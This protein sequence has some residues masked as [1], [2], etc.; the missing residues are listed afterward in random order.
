MSSPRNQST[1]PFGSHEDQAIFLSSSYGDERDSS[2]HDE[3]PD[4]TRGN[5]ELPKK[6]KGKNKEKAS[7]LKVTQE[8]RKNDQQPTAHTNIEFGPPTPTTPKR[9]TSDNSYF[10]WAKNA[11]SNTVS[12]VENGLNALDQKA[13]RVANKSYGTITSDKSSSSNNPKPALS[14]PLAPRIEIDIPPSMP[15]STFRRIIDDLIINPL[16]SAAHYAK[17]HPASVIIGFLSSIPGGIYSFCAFSGI[18]PKNLVE[19]VANMNPA[20]LM[21]AI[22]SAFSSVAPNTVMNAAFLAGLPVDFKKSI[23]VFLNKRS[24][25]DGTAQNTALFGS[26][27]PGALIVIAA[28][29]TGVSV[30]FSMYGIGY[31][32]ASW[33]PMA[34]YF[35][36]IPGLLNGV[37]S[38]SN[39]FNSM[40]QFV[41]KLIDEFGA[42]AD[43]KL[44]SSAIDKLSHLT[45]YYE[46]FAVNHLK[47]KEINRESII[48]LFAA[49]QKKLDDDH[50]VFELNWSKK[51]ETFSKI[52]RVLMAASIGYF[53]F[54]TFDIKGFMG[55]DEIIK[56]VSGL[57]GSEKS[58]NDI[59]EIAKGFIGALPGLA[60]SLFY[61]IHMFDFTTI[62]KSTF[63]NIVFDNDTDIVNIWKKIAESFTHDPVTMM[64]N[65]IKA[66]G[67][68]VTCVFS[69]ANMYNVAAGIY[70]DKTPDNETK[71][72]MNGLASIFVNIKCL[73]KSTFPAPSNELVTLVKAMKL[74][75]TNSD[76]F[77]GLKT[78]YEFEIKSSKSPEEILY[79]NEQVKVAEEVILA[80]DPEKSTKAINEDEAERQHL[81][82]RDDANGLLLNKAKECIKTMTTDD[83]QLLRT[84]SMFNNVPRPAPKGSHLHDSDVISHT[85]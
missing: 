41:L 12:Y 73:F 23:N 20:E 50:E 76:E 34:K 42:D 2:L 26:N 4:T 19:G 58:I 30:F 10:S 15:K 45:K 54:E 31:A 66:L 51:S 16:G 6:D 57:A 60:T 29:L 69:G 39:R 11:V 33:L 28:L 71:K 35:A 65:L 82:P 5:Q 81:L 55:L 14:V 70:K 8:I 68:I 17:D 37:N 85:I 43:T 53:V 79:I 9:A 62:L 72:I 21:L 59:P 80:H 46:N 74:A 13:N 48:S 63:N 1:T 77:K 36:H 25:E 3:I 32:S 47:N 18:E 84:F 40:N 49:L 67:I 44:K 38:F 61:A 64:T 83:L 78:A 52:A 27:I 56:F 7:P 75:P 22:W 24:N